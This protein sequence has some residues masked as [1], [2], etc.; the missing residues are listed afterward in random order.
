MF[1]LIC[2]C[3][4][5]C[6]LK[7]CSN[8]QSINCVQSND[9]LLDRLS[10]YRPNFSTEAAILRV[11]S[12]NLHPGRWRRRLRCSFRTTRPVGY[13]WYGRPRKF[14]ATSRQQM[15]MAPVV[16]RLSKLASSITTFRCYIHQLTAKFRKDYFLI[17]TF[18]F[19]IYMLDSVEWWST[20]YSMSAYLCW[21]HSNIR[22]LFARWNRRPICSRRSVRW[23]VT[24]FRVGWS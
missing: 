8:K 24:T 11:L 14:T 4:I 6:W 3:R 18:I 20:V 16:H 10:A 21:R 23:R 9:I 2:R 7:N 15:I 22:P 1:D 12:D 13:I 17:E 19:T 5:F